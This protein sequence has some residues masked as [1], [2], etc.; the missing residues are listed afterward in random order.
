VAQRE[1]GRGDGG[2]FYPR[3]GLHGQLVDSLG[4]DIV[5]G[6]YAPGD[7]LDVTALQAEREV[8][9]TAL[10]EALRVLG[11]KGLVE[12]R[13]KRGTLVR[14]ASAWNLLDP[15]V[16]RW[17]LG[18]Q[19]GPGML[20][21]LAE[22]RAIV[23]PPAARL[24]AERRTDAD[25]EALA[26]A[27]D[28][29][30]SSADDPAAHAAAD[31][32][33]HRALLAASGNDLLARIGAVFATV[34]LVRDELVHRTPGH[35]DD[36]RAPHEAVLEAIRSQ[37]PDDAHAAMLELQAKARSDALLAAKPGDRGVAA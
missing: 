21:A 27:L 13:Q 17:Q 20:E 6:Q 35:R 33:F 5:T 34:L 9:K 23:E 30:V 18:G 14:P 26:A 1:T 24:A 31:V 37:R 16:L 19:S 28:A 25:L 29:M 2:G 7:T 15:D 32:A 12:A 4:R 11:G 36:F 22:V 3:R 10:R 8:S